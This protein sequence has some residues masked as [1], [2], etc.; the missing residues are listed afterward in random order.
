MLIPHPICHLLYETGEKGDIFPLE[1]VRDGL[2]KGE[3]G[4]GLEKSA[5]API[6]TR[7]FSKSTD[8]KGDR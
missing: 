5:R 4:D 1:S 6:N 3:G 2:K 8:K 7:F